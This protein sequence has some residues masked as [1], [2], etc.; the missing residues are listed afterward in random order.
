MPKKITDPT[1]LKNH[2]LRRDKKWRK[3]HHLTDNRKSIQ[4]ISRLSVTPKYG[5]KKT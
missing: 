3:Q 2:A 5:K 4:L 1:D